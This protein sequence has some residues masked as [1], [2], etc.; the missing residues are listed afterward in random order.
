MDSWN[1]K[2]GYHIHTTNNQNIGT[3]VI[4]CS[5]PI[6]LSK[7]LASLTIKKWFS[8]NFRTVYGKFYWFF[9][10]FIFLLTYF[11][12]TINL[13]T[14][15]KPYWK[16]KV[17]D[18][19]TADW[20]TAAALEI[21]SSAD[22][23]FSCLAICYYS[24]FSFLKIANHMLWHCFGSEN[25]KENKRDDGF[26]YYRHVSIK[27]KSHFKWPTWVGLWL[28]KYPRSLVMWEAKC[29]SQAME[30]DCQILLLLFF[31]IPHCY[32]CYCLGNRL[33]LFQV[34]LLLWNNILFLHLLWTY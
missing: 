7:S 8:F 24:P 34:A 9:L 19:Q 22:K 31:Y 4:T 16:Q 21:A 23:T 15:E 33:L 20:I 18:H 26:N 29:P 11:E 3:K 25:N 14:Y 17:M 28:R 32:S 12:R 2:Y 6:H 27:T 13:V 1:S 5:L 30:E 10:F